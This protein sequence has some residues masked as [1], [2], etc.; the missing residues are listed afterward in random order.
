MS[1]SAPLQEVILRIRQGI[2][3]SKNML[4]VSLEVPIGLKT[5]ATVIPNT[6]RP[7]VVNKIFIIFS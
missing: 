7:R 5:S 3:L 4:F 2:P 6:D 1:A